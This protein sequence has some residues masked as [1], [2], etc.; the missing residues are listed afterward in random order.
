MIHCLHDSFRR[1]FDDPATVKQLDD[2]AFRLAAMEHDDLLP[3]LSILFL[4]LSVCS[5]HKV[6]ARMST[7]AFSSKAVGQALWAFHRGQH[8][9]LIA[10]QRNDMCRVVCI[11]S[12]RRAGFHHEPP[13]CGRKTS[14]LAQVN[15]TFITEHPQVMSPLAKWHRSKTGLTERFEL[16]V[17]TK[18]ICN[19][20]TELTLGDPALREAGCSGSC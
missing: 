19:A 11:I 16:F 14:L 12:A 15:P 7:T 2:L 10:V 18:E 5:G 20:Y 9:P 3:K 4:K 17:N 6:G 1:N 13:L 8:C